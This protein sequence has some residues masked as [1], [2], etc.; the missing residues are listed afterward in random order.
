M[1]KLCLFVAFPKKPSSSELN[2]NIN[3][4]KSNVGHG[5]DEHGYFYKVHYKKD[6]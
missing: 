1:C 5:G 6:D 3:F 4:V 2:K